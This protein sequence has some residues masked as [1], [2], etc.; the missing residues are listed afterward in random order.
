VFTTTAVV[1]KAEVQPETVAVTEYVPAITAV[2]GPRVGSSKAEA[3]AEGP[4]QEYV[5]PAIVFDVKL[6]VLPVQTGVLLPAVG[7]VG[8]VFT[9]NVAL[10]PAILVQPEAVFVTV[11]LYVPAIAAVAPVILGF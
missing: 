4:V 5:A 10:A 6:I 3:K 9:T 7:A 11:T 2:A 1:P 8:V